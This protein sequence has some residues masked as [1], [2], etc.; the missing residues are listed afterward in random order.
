MVD[1]LEQFVETAGKYYIP[2]NNHVKITDETT[3]FRPLFGFRTFRRY[4]VE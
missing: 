1:I 2:R 4:M 3:E